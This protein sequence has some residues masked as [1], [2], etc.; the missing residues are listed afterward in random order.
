MA[1]ELIV[2]AVMAAKAG[3]KLKAR[4]LLATAIKQNH[5]NELAWS[6]MFTVV[7]SDEQRLRCLKE[8]LRINPSNL[9]ARQ[10]LEKLEARL[11]RPSSFTDGLP[12]EPKPS[13]PYIGPTINNPNPP[14]SPVRSIPASKEIPEPPEKKAPQTRPGQDKNEPNPLQRGSVSRSDSSENKARKRSGWLILILLVLILVCLSLVILHYTFPGQPTITI[15]PD[16]SPIL[17]TTLQTETTSPTPTSTPSQTETP[18]ITSSPQPQPTYLALIPYNYRET[19]LGD[20]WNGGSLD[21]AFENI[22]DHYVMANDINRIINNG[23]QGASVETLEGKTYSV[24]VNIIYHWD[25]DLPT[26]LPTGYLVKSAVIELYGW[27]IGGISF[28]FAQAAH[29]TRV[30]FPSHP[31][32]DIDLTTVPDLSVF[33]SFPEENLKSIDSL[34]GRVIVD[35]PQQLNVSIS[36]IDYTRGDNSG[37]TFISIILELTGK[38]LDQLDDLNTSIDFPFIEV[39]APNGSIYLNFEQPV[40]FVMGPGQEYKNTYRIFGFGGPYNI[41]DTYY[42]LVRWSEN[43]YEMF[44]LK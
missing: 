13:V 29:P 3:D 22:S 33:N 21:I 24:G 37:N 11:I 15:T 40:G 25:G 28:K 8:V 36:N 44:T 35:Q 38:N 27:S 31:E 1:D 41:N 12:V 43:N 7:D 6:W 39:L 20:G 9:K 34:N 32:W 14:G 17:T 26:I 5:D 2:Q 19:V 4:E 30:V 16:G 18:T 23:L 10:A 42:L